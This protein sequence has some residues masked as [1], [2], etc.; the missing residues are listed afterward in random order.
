M[1]FWISVLVLSIATSAI[2]AQAAEVPTTSDLNCDLNRNP[3]LR[4]FMTWA[5]LTESQ[6]TLREDQTM[7]KGEWSVYKSCCPAK[8]FQQYVSAS[9]GSN[10][11][12]NWHAYMAKIKEFRSGSLSKLKAVFNKIANNKQK[13][14]QKAKNSAK[15]TGCDM[16][17]FSETTIERL[18]VFSQDYDK[19]QGEYKD[20]AARC[21]NDLKILK[22]NTAC[23]V[24]SGR[25]WQ[26]ISTEDGS[27]NS[28][29]KIFRIKAESCRKILDSCGKVFR[30]TYI[31]QEI[32]QMIQSLRSNYGQS[33]KTRQCIDN[34]D[35]YRHEQ[36]GV[37]FAQ[38]I[39]GSV[40]TCTEPN[41]IILCKSFLKLG[42][43]NKI[44]EGD[45]TLLNDE[46]R[47]DTDSTGSLI[48]NR[49]LQA[50]DSGY[51]GY[52]EVVGDSSVNSVGSNNLF[53]EGSGAVPNTAI[54]VAYMADDSS[55]SLLVFVS[56]I[57]ATL[58][59]LATF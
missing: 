54:S 24:C 30:Y 32:I 2:L 58:L 4:T 11:Q 34:F 15:K 23:T 6:I 46:I 53:N 45:S 14:S 17:N 3:A 33:R 43:S 5:G 49:I 41:A 9:I 13:W 37:A 44:S 56:S 52:Y 18:K 19:L 29:S 57:M 8:E 28:G 25:G 10:P 21:F 38:C 22:T 39:D 48:D 42:E 40:N 55:N 20:N 1:K 26:M 50:V 7:C 27:I 31:F 47:E 16:T 36:I 59:L 35:S 12:A 51:S